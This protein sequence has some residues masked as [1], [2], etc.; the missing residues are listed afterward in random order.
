MKTDITV[1]LSIPVTLPGQTPIDAITLR[2]AK[3]IDHLVADESSEDEGEQNINLLANL[4]G[5]SPDV[6]LEMDMADFNKV[7]AA[8][9]ELEDFEPVENYQTGDP[10]PL[11]SPVEHEDGSKLDYIK[12]RRPKVKDIIRAQKETTG[13]DDRK[14]LFILSILADVPIEDIYNLDRVDELRVLS[15]YLDFLS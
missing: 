14:R 4:A 3:A 1:P 11:L 15:A 13:G 7:K 10:L 6:F 5:V 12:L 2:R 9:A 8:N